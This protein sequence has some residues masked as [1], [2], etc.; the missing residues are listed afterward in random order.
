MFMSEGLNQHRLWVKALSMWL[1]YESRGGYV[2]VEGVTK[3]VGYGQTQDLADWVALGRNPLWRPVG[4]AADSMDLNEE[5]DVFWD[6]TI[7][8]WFDRFSY[9]SP[10]DNDRWTD[11]QLVGKSG[12]LDI[13]AAF[14]FTGR[15]GCTEW[16]MPGMEAMEE[17]NCPW[18][19][20]DKVDDLYNILS[21]VVHGH[22]YTETLT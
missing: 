19:W 18:Q 21:R 3:C 14:F 2:E 12:F 9:R 20:L 6:T 22:T 15:V 10:E 7:P 16:E 5:L 13:F 17:L 4:G 8:G 1:L 11:W